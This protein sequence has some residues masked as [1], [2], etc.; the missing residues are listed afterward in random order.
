MRRQIAQRRQAALHVGGV[1]DHP[2]D[3]P[4]RL[5]E[6]LRLHVAGEVAGRHGPR[7]RA[8]SEVDPVVEEAPHVDRDA[9]QADGLHELPAAIDPDRHRRFAAARLGIADAKHEPDERA[10]PGLHV[11]GRQADGPAGVDVHVTGV[12]GLGVAGEIDRPVR[13]RVRARGGENERCR[14]GLAGAAVDGVVRDGHA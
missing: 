14:V 4:Q 10:G 9:A 7:V 2:V 11:R 8:A 6:R 3:D 5:L 13:D 12:S 1:V